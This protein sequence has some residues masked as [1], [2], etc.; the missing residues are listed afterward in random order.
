MIDY[1]FSIVLGNVCREIS[2]ELVLPTQ[3]VLLEAL[4][5]AAGTLRGL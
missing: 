2:V 5:V 1:G 4:S 3:D